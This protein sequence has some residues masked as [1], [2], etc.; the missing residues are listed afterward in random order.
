MKKV[1]LLGL[2]LALCL[3][4]VGLGF[5]LFQFVERLGPGRVAGPT[6]RTLLVYQIDRIIDADATS[7][8]IVDAI[9]Q[10]LDP[11]GTLQVAVKRVDPDL[12]EIRIPRRQPDHD[13]LVEQLKTLLSM[14]GDLQFRIL[15]NDRDDRDAV[16]VGLA[17]FDEAAKLSAEQRLIRT[18]VHDRL[19]K[20]GLSPPGPEYKGNRS[21]QWS[22]G[23][24]N[25]R[26][27]YSWIA[28]ASSACRTKDSP[29]NP[30]C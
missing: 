18:A 30:N 8:Q 20:A 22:T 19:A 16:E 24:D 17:E 6:S 3:V 9:R 25:G 21:F 27:T 23:H 1:L 14:T 12:I 29:T 26:A 15:A 28:R 4:V 5:G 10:R 11:Y 2:A 13:A 7:G